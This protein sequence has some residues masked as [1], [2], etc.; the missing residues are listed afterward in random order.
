MP[1]TAPSMSASAAS[2][3]TASI[4]IRLSPPS[5]LKRLWPVYLVCRKRSKA[6]AS[7]SLCRIW[8]WSSLGS[9][10]DALDVLLDPGLL[11]RLGVVH[12]LDGAGAAVG[13]AQDV[14]DLAQRRLL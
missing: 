8:S 4:R 10:E 14:Q 9:S 2:S 5:R 6:S 7:L 13:V 3:R 1:M 12:V 11:V